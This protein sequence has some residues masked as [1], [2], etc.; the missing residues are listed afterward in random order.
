MALDSFLQHS[1]VL[2][3]LY[4]LIPLACVGIPSLIIGVLQAA[5]QIQDQTWPF[6]IRM[7]TFVAVCVFGW[8]VFSSAMVELMH[9]ALRLMIAVGR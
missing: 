3:G 6:L 5:T 4:S 1:I 8:R 9:E 2:I 7:G